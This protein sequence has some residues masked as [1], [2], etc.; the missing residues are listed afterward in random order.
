[1]QTFVW[2]VQVDH[3]PV[4]V[5]LSVRSSASKLS[6]KDDENGTLQSGPGRSTDWASCAFW[7]FPRLVAVCFF[8][9]LFAWVY[10]AEGG[11]GTLFLHVFGL[12]ALL[13]SLF[14]LVF[15]Q[16]SILVFSA[17][18]LQPVARRFPT[19]ALWM[20]SR[21]YHSTLHVVGLVCCA[22][23][24]VAIIEYKA[25]SP[26][27]VNFPFYTMYSPHSWLAICFL[28][29]WGLQFASG[30]Y[31]QMCGVSSY[32]SWSKYH[33]FLGRVVYAVGLAV[34]A[35]G[36]QDMQA[37]DLAGS[38]PPYVSTANFTQDQTDN[39]GYY[40]NSQMAQLSCVAVMLLM[41]QAIATFLTHI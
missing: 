24:L 5:E 6:V 13:M 2:C 17:P 21:A 31:A 32:A 34:C 8:G 36:F 1:V 25:L 22:G 28:G 14:V 3:D 4:H 18:L 16:E 35:L 30:I 19:V 33:R 12:H 29:L 39:M 11:L 9:V 10:Q 38:V 41:I 7:A 27:P 23:G 15:T 26:S 37:S 20:S 40:P